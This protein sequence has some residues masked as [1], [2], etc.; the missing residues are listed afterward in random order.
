MMHTQKVCINHFMDQQTVDQLNF[1][2]NSISRNNEN[3]KDILITLVSI[4]LDNKVINKN[5]Y[6]KILKK[7]GNK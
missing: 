6:N 4:L 3:T 1:A 5:Q 7:I 2:A